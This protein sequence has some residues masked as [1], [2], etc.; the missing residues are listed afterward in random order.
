[1]IW[2]KGINRP[3]SMGI[4]LL[5]K[6]DP[7]GFFGSKTEAAVIEYQKGRGLEETGVVD[8]SVLDI[9][10]ADGLSLELRILEMI[11]CFETGGMTIRNPWASVSTIKDGAGKNWGVMQVNGITGGSA[12]RLK[13]N[14]MPAGEDFDSWIG[15]PSGAKGQ[16][17]YFLD[18]IYPTALRFAMQQNDSSD[19]V[20]AL[21]CDN[22]TQNGSP[23]PYYP[24]RSDSMV[25]D[26]KQ[27]D[28][29]KE[30]RKVIYKNY[31]G[32]MDNRSEYGTTPEREKAYVQK[33]REA[34]LTCLDDADSLGIPRMEAY[35][36]LNPRS[37]NPDF[38]DDLLSRRRTVYHG[39]GRVHG[40]KYFMEEFGI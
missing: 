32:L 8:R 34:F 3:M 5:V 29:Y 18:I 28:A 12:Y 19:R 26:W 25:Q 23:M 4:Q 35:V 6:C 16:A 40:D 38:L 39:S 2:Q 31:K 1:M 36:E 13:K 15:S 37:G 14:Y 10:V 22:I 20:L 11:A 9:M 7:D 21:L 30:W 17:Q 33:V 24:I 27:D